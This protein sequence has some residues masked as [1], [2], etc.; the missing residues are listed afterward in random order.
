[1]AALIVCLSKDQEANADSFLCLQTC[2]VHSGVKGC[3]RKHD[4]KIM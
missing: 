4:A 2:Y 1:M 3:Q